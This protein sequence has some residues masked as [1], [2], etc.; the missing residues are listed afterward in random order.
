MKSYS[1]NHGKREMKRFRKVAVFMGGPSSEAEVSIRSGTA[2]AKGL[3]ECGY[4]VQ[5]VVLRDASFVVPTGVDAIFLALHGAYGEDGS[6]QAELNRRG[7]PYTGS[8]AQASRISFDKEE[9]K[10]VLDRA[11][12]PTAA[13]RPVQAGATCPLPFPVVVKPT[14]EGS[15]IGV[16][17]VDGADAWPSALAEALRHGGRA[18]AEAFIP[19]RELTVGVVD[20]ETLPVVE[21]E[22]PSGWYSF[23]AKYTKGACR[24]TVPANLPDPLAAACRSI[25]L[26]TYKALGCRGMGRVDFRLAPDGGLF[27]LEMNTI[28]GFTETSLL[29]KSAAA[30]GIVFSELC[31]RIMESAAYDK[32]E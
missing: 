13:W 20:G 30:A 11:G 10:R 18:I 21:I 4:D 24:Y 17:R 16:H 1:R 3:R 28:P 9:T 2:I 26:R 12:I 14:C 5:E 29:P 22:A 15:S 7:I 31:G 8:G 19:G 32:A 27:V 6:I 23:D 25:G